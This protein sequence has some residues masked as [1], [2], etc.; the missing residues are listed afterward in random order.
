MNDQE[1]LSRLERQV[2]RYRNLTALLLLAVVALLASGAGDPVPEVLRARRFEMVAE[3]GRPLAALRP[4]STG[5]AIGIFNLKGEPA[6]LL[7]ADATGGG[8]LNIISAQGRNGVLMLGTNA[9]QTGGAVTVYNSA[10]QEVVT[11]RPDP[12]G[13]GL[14][15]AWDGQKRGQTLRGGPRREL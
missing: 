3:D 2:R 9:D 13:V 15:G 8:L 12:A 1:R 7:T 11:L 6:G 10:E 4:T 5:G 14:M